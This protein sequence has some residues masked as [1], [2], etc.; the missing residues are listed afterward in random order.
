M[1]TRELYRASDPTPSKQQHSWRCVA[2]SPQAALPWFYRAECAKEKVS[3]KG[4]GGTQPPAPNF[5]I[6]DHYGMQTSVAAAG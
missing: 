3:R 5:T 1:L 4:A 6:D 2:Q